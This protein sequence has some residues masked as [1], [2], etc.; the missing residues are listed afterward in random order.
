MNNTNDLLLA[1][2]NLLVSKYKELREQYTAKQE[3]WSE[4]EVYF[5]HIDKVARE[6]CEEILAKDKDEMVLGSDYS[7]SSVK[8]DEL[9]HKAK[10]SFQNYNKNRTEL[11]RNI[12]DLAENR[13]FQI[14]S[15]QDQI[16]QFMTGN[17]IAAISSA[18]EIVERA[19][20]KA[21][22]KAAM[23]K[24]P[25]IAKS[26]AEAGK[27][28]LIIEDMDEVEVEGE[29]KPLQDLMEQNEQARIT[30]YSIP[31]NDSTKKKKKMKKER[32]NAVLAHMVDLREFEDQMTDGM[33]EILYVIGSYGLSKYPDIEAKVLKETDLRKTKIRTSMQ[34]IYKMGVVSQEVLNLP[35]SPKC[36]VYK[37][38]DIGLRLYKLKYEGDPVE[39]ELDRIIK[40][41]DNP[42]HGYGIMDVVK[43]LEDSGFYKEVSG[44]NRNHA[45]NVK[46]GKRYIP[47]IICVT[48]RYKEYIEYERG[49][50]TQADFNEKCNKMTQVT[51]YL[52]FVVPNK[53]ILIKRL[54]PQINTWIKSRDAR[55][56]KNIKIRLTTALT[57]KDADMRNDKC[58]QVIWDLRKGAAPVKTIE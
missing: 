44:Y 45:I 40:E 20:K 42:N 13:Q 34:N 7:W 25:H 35:L 58:W 18:Q 22:E 9:I 4:R 16:E 3:R 27:V 17:N 33:W 23:D 8:T 30:A 11:M 5:K 29:M 1:K 56:L 32:D 21:E 37:L 24:A 43:I 39:A 41:H 6:L 31:V 54:I 53:D 49:M 19:E 52:N 55:S 15:L 38:S 28:Q 57:L 2:Y 12:M 46:D 47:D 36:F 51:R 14:V 26:A 50:H 48:D 10:K